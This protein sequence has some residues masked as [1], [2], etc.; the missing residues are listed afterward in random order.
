MF[1]MNLIIIHLHTY[2]HG[3]ISTT[4]FYSTVL[5]TFCLNEN[6]ILLLIANYTKYLR[7]YNIIISWILVNSNNS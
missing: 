3:L 7:Y 1:Y 4:F 5:L 2:I 6:N